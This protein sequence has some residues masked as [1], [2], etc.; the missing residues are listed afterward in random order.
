M[1]YKLITQINEKI[2]KEMIAL[3]EEVF[4]KE[5]VGIFSKCKEWISANPD[6]YTVLTY[7]N[8]VIAYINFIPISN[9]FYRKFKTGKLKD[10]SLTSKDIISFNSSRP[11]KCLFTSIVIHQNFRNGETFEKLWKGFINKLKGFD[12]KISSIIM[13]CV[14]NIGELCAI[15]F[16]DG[17][18]ICNSATGKIYEGNLNL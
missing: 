2:L 8:K 12:F 3:D 6:I 16:L 9:T 14:T 11:I 17:K 18:F 5:D 1:T 10:L 4:K 7:E 15:K 13:D